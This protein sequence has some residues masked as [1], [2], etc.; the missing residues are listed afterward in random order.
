MIN[1]HTPK[2]RN[3]VALI[4]SFRIF[5]FHCRIVRVPPGRWGSLWLAFS[6]ANSV[7]S[8]N[9]RSSFKK[10]STTNKTKHLPTLQRPNSA[11]F[12]GLLSDFERLLEQPAGADVHFMIDHEKV[13]AHRLIVLA[14]CERYRTKK[15]FNQQPDNFPLVVQ[16]G[17]HLSAAAVRDVVS[18]L[19]TGKV[20]KI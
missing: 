18:Y 13:T 8:S 6:L 7:S 2:E 15:R 3:F 10:M 17:K 12:A 1:P 5:T 9:L 11:L 19:Y 16:L 4:A 20:R 14:R